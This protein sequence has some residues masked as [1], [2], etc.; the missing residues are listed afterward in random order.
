MNILKKTLALVVVS[1]ASLASFANA[2]SSIF[3]GP[4]VAIQG[5][6]AGI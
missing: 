4:Y 2:D 5:S 6:A 3:A 1:V